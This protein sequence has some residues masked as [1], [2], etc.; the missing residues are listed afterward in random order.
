MSPRNVSH[1]EY[2]PSRPFDRL[3]VDVIWRGNN[4]QIR[5]WALRL[6]LSAPMK[7]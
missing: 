3:G 2:I 1:S 5:E 6:A 7:Q 4:P